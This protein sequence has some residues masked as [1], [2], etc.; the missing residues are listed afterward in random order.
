M[1]RVRWATTFKYEDEQW[2]EKEGI[3]IYRADDIIED[4]TE[5]PRRPWARL[6][7]LGTFIEL[8][9][10]KKAS[11]NLYVVEIPAGGALEPEKHLYDELLYV[12][13]GRGL[14]EVWHE[15]QSKVSFEFG[16][17]SLFAVPLNAWH[18]LVNGG[19][20]PVLIYGES[21]A[22]VIMNTLRNIDFVF[23][24]PYNFDDRFKGEAD[25]FVAN[26]RYKD[27]EKRFKD[28][29][30]RGGTIWETNFVP[31]VR[32]ASFVLDPSQKDEGR[33]GVQFKMPNW[34]KMHSSD[35]P[36]GHYSA[37]H[38]HGP[39]AVIIGLK[40]E[41]YSLLWERQYGIH[42]YKDGHEDKVL[43]VAWKAGSI[44]SPQDYVFHAHFNTGKEPH[45]HLR[46][47]GGGTLGLRHA[48]LEGRGREGSGPLQLSVR[49]GG[50]Q[51]AYEDEDPAIRPA[52]EEELRKNGVESSMEPVVYRTDPFKFAF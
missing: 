13:Q 19:R 17:G 6:G 15:G 45:R 27:T 51:I 47:V 33:Q 10:T 2:M 35:M 20:E 1:E 41:G 36:V 28:L 43:K 44:F 25:Y 39:G 32:N 48:T 38:Y 50:T 22:P 21:S 14:V 30:P 49:K 26:K 23:N 16:E 11:L 37:A 9:A 29:E 42:P 40:G 24:C 52:W 34:A 5:L 31:D 8:E 12:L 4:M 18:R 7:G 46:I 3:P